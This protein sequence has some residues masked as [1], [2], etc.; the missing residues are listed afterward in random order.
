[1]NKH[2][3]DERIAYRITSDV[4]RVSTRV[5]RGV[6]EIVGEDDDRRTWLYNS[7]DPD[8]L[9]ALFSQKHSGGSREDGKVV[10]TARGCK[11]VVHGDGEIHIYAPEAHDSDE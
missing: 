6:E 2:D 11:I 10:F 9:D 1:M 4:D 5:I 3:T 8:A 7:I